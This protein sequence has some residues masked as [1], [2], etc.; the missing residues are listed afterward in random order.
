MINRPGA[1]PQG[2]CGQRWSVELDSVR[3]QI[4]DRQEY[5]QRFQPVVRDVLVADPSTAAHETVAR[6]LDGE[7]EIQPVDSIISFDDHG[8]GTDLGQPGSYCRVAD[9]PCLAAGEGRRGCVA[10]MSSGQG[11][12]RTPA[13]RRLWYQRGHHRRQRIEAS[14]AQC[15]EKCFRRQPLKITKIGAPMQDHRKARRFQLQ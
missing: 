5:L 12:A 2:R 9:Q 11:R 6:E 4:A 7:V 1:G 10:I 13:G 15:G 3:G 14:R 8:V